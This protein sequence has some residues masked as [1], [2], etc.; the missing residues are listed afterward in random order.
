MTDENTLLMPDA[1]LD[2]LHPRRDRPHV[3]EPAAPDPCLVDEAR[4]RVDAARD[5]IDELGGAPGTDPEIADALAPT[6]AANADPLGAAAIA[7]ALDHEQRDAAFVEAWQ[8]EHG[9]AFAAA[10]FTAAGGIEAAWKSLR[11]LRA[12]APLGFRLSRTAAKR[13]AAA[14]PPPT[15]TCTPRPSTRSAGTAATIC[16][17]SSPPTSRRPARTGSRICAPTRT[18]P[19]NGSATSGG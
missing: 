7:V 4:S 12:D 11:P 1:W 19:P 18:G 10:A 8:A 9:A 16:S 2:E 13:C 14:W 6:C 17:G 5:E 15:T 3:P